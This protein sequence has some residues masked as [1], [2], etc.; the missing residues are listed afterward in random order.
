MDFL[1][2]EGPPDKFLVVTHEL[3]VQNKNG[4]IGLGPCLASAAASASG[5]NSSKLY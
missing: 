2:V 1:V 5:S 3:F 4:L